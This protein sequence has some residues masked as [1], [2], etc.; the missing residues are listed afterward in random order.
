[1]TKATI[2]GEVHQTLDVH[3]GLAAEVAFD[4][5]V[6]VDRLAEVKHLL[7]GQIL[8]AALG[9][10]AELGGD[11]FRL[12]T[13]DA[14]DIGKGDLDA[15]VGRDIDARDTCHGL[16]SPAPQAALASRPISALLQSRNKQSRRAHG[17][18]A[19]YR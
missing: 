5:V 11:L 3:R 8:D 18:A 10:D 15:L 12:G 14:V 19:G 6:G 1:M 9:G 2:A 17:C 4:L 16:C 13:A 7:V